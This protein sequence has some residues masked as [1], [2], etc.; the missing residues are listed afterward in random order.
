MPSSSF[1]NMSA[2][3]DPVYENKQY[4][5]GLIM[6]QC[7]ISFDDLNHTSIVRAKV[8]EA[9]IDSIIES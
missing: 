9:K 5:L 8:R 6:K 7:G 3:V 2:A 4:L 1:S